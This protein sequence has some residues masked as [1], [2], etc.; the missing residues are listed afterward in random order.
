MPP[1][2]RE[3][4]R[5]AI[6]P[7]GR[8]QQGRPGKARRIAP[9]KKAQK[10]EITTPGAQKRVIRIEDDIQ[11]QTLA[12]RMSLK[13]TDVLMKLLQLGMGGVNINSTLDADTAKLLASEF[14]YEVENVAISDE[15]LVQEARGRFK[16]EGGD[17]QVRAPVVTVMGHVDHGKTSL[18]DRLRRTD[19]VSGEAGGITQHLG[20]YRLDTAQGSVVFLDTPG[21]EAFT[22]MRARGAQAT[23][24]VVLVV[25][26]D[27]GVM[28]QTKEAINHA[29]DAKVPIVVAVNKIDR[30]QA[31]PD[32]IRT[33]LAK[34]GL[35]PEEWGGDTIAVNVSAHTG[36]GLD[37]LLESV[38]LQS[39]MLELQ[40]NPRVPGEG[41]V[42]EAYLD[43]GRGPVASML[44]RNG[45]LRTGDFVVAGGAW[46]K[47][48]AMTD[49]RGKQA[50]QALPSTPVE[51]LG[52]S[53][54]P[55]AGDAFYVVTDTK[56]AQQLADRR[57]APRAAAG[58]APAK[59]G[60]DQLL[61]LQKQQQGE[62][63]ELKVVVKA[64]VQGSA[65]ALV[66]ALADLSTDSVKVHVIHSGVGGITENDV[67][68]ASASNATVIG[69]HVRPAG[70][71]AATAKSEGVDI[72]LYAV[73]Y[74]AIDDVKKAMSGLLAPKLVEKPLGRAEVRRVFAIPK[75]GAI[76]GCFV[77][78]GKMLRSGKVR[79][80]RDST[81][82]WEGQVRSLRRF[83]EDVR[84]VTSGYECGI[85]LDGFGDI[86][87]HD[88]IECFELEEV[89]ATL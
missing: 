73:I 5:A 62:L 54:V 31:R 59:V 33:E 39:E 78:D 45:M 48:R 86:K 10:T 11:L 57:R 23:D 40:A 70:G 27:D 3:L 35:Q 37:K 25:A 63:Q 60:L 38:L 12:Q 58:A 71:A 76:A 82:V 51:V 79:L 55:G 69:F 28:P 20:A 61:Q 14:D 67:M 49:D 41:V 84:E 56:A 36:E 34:E 9:G 29:R 32:Q 42:L 18:L 53:E 6:G 19:V 65:E 68:L 2:R 74:E 81:Q 22:A 80:V 46:G 47:V 43:R 87:E 13:A 66:K 21:H 50:A 17:W 4:A 15:E 75:I 83:K 77:L 52:L 85:S 26:A 89:E 72:R 7:T 64:D 24:I 88:I 8:T 1:R 30:E 44:V 16:D